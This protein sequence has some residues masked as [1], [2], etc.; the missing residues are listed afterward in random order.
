MPGQ[1]FYFLA[2]ALSRLGV[3]YGNRVP[4]PQLESLCACLLSA[5]YRLPGGTEIHA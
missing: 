1:N 4:I 3:Q 2:L 5:L